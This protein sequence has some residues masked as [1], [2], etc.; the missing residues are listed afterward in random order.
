[1]EALQVSARE[2][3]LD[4][5]S[6]ERGPSDVLFRLTRGDVAVAEVSLQAGSS[7]PEITRAR[8]GWEGM[9]L[10]NTTG[11]SFASFARDGYT[12][13]PDPVDR[14]LSIPPDPPLRYGD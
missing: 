9:V 10:L 1:M 4:A 13:L 2:V 14:P 3:P 11:S 6:G 12:T 5:A 7:G 8:S